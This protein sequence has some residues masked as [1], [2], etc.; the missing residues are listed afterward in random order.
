MW[1]GGHNFGVKRILDPVPLFEESWNSLQGRALV[2]I[3]MILACVITCSM[4][5]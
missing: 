1:G 3:V 2:V 5:G 4:S